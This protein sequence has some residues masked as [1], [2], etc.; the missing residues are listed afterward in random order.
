VK[1]SNNQ[2]AFIALVRAGLWNQAIELKRFGCLDYDSILQL[3]EE[4]SVAGL[5]TAG[6]EQVQDMKVPQDVVLQFVGC[7][8]QIEQRNKELNEFIPK[9]FRKLRSEG[10]DAVLVKGQGVAQRYEKP[11]WRAS[12]DVDLLLSN[13]NYE[14][15]KKVLFPIAYDIGTEESWKKHQALKIMGV[16]V[17]LHGKMP[18]GLSKKVDDVV[19]GVVVKALSEHE[20]SILNESVRI[21]KVDEHVFL[22]FTH[23]LRHFFIEGVGLR[24]ICDW[25]RM[26]WVY[27]SELDLR[28]LEERIRKAGLGMEWNVFGTLAVNQLGMPIEAMPLFNENNNHNENLK[29]KA[30]MV[31][32]R[33][34]K[35]GNFGHNNDLSYRAKYRGMT[36]RVVATWRRFWDFTLL[37]PLFPVDAPMFFVRYVF[38]KVKRDRWGHY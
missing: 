5:V 20:S 17:E 25:C 1:L 18:F 24:Q 14:K 21:P 15:A 8:L 36:Y 9:L 2:E 13:S 33:V 28:V 12:G 22:V 30:A 6:L 4:Q 19:D 32:K 37:V 16:E 34:M 38:G 23:F 3:A 27:Q 35:S 31:L 10:V 29:K 26:L 7:T 11:L